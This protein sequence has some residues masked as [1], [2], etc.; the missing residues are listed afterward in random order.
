MINGVE[1][2]DPRLMHW[3]WCVGGASDLASH[4]LLGSSN[5]MEGKLQLNRNQIRK[6]EA[7]RA[8]FY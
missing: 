7:K 5:H 6:P 8:P 2:S 4:R 1:N 3:H